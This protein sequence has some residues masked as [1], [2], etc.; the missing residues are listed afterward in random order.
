MPLKPDF[1]KTI[2]EGFS[3]VVKG[4]SLRRDTLV[5][6]GFRLKPPQPKLIGI[7]AVFK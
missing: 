4:T 5:R 7:Q 6:K 1:S 2:L 3:S